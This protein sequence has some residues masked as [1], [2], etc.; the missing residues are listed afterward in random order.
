[1]N[2]ALNGFFWFAAV[3]LVLLLAA[4]NVT[5]GPLNQDEGVYLHAG[6]LLW[7]GRLPFV[8]HAFTQGPVTALSYALAAPLVSAQGLLG[9]R[10]FAA[11][12]GLGALFFTVRIAAC[13][14]PRGVRG[15]AAFVAL[16]LAGA[17]AHQ[18]YFLSIA[19]TYAPAA[20]F[21]MAGVWF[22]LR[23][24]ESPHPRPAAIA[25]L[26]LALAAGTRLS[27]GIWLPVAGLALVLRRRENGN[28]P[29][30]AFGLA[31]AVTLAVVYLPF[32][33]FSWSSLKFG[34]LDYHAA[35]H[36]G[37]GLGALAFKAGF[38]SR[39]ARV[40]LPALALLAVCGALAQ[41]LR[42]RIDPP[43][44][45]GPRGALWTM[46]AL[47]TLVHLLTP[48]PYD[49]YQV[50]VFP[51]VAA[52]AASAL[53]RLLHRLQMPDE[54]R[55]GLMAWVSAALLFVCGTGA[56]AAEINQE[57][58][59]SGRDRIW[60]VLKKKPDVLA[61]RDAART[62]R[63]MAGDTREILTQDAYL[64]VEA[65][66]RLPPGL[67][68]GPFAFCADFDDETAARLHVVNRA[69]L[70]HLIETSP[71]RVA[72]ASGYSFTIRSP[73]ITPLERAIIDELRAALEARTAR[74]ESIPR[75]GQ[76]ATTL[77]LRELKAPTQ[78][79]LPVTGTP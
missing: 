13:L 44:S 73:D 2:R 54:A 12:L 5:L 49:D 14:S 38:L 7:E 30:L 18:S 21:A 36:G 77:E 72:A 63:E 43:S 76:G 53:A 51:L 16:L 65:R 57:W 39:T 52:L 79:A 41:A 56:F 62:A 60:W 29:W 8:H 58:M 27:L 22:W 75:F 74:M 34:L 4:L 46:A 71:A 48:F 31:G 3:A 69:G 59:V 17:S 19:K 64:A 20:C 10:I 37:E 42:G 6:S 26:L 47:I 78:A 50:V 25:G 9:G 68:L 32:A 61:L 35:R 45:A 1:M 40:W 70:L 24:M 67:E 11:L 23:A 55:G 66:L 33:L 15:V 28:A